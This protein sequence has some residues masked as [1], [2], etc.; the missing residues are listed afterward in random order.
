M[1]CLCLI[2]HIL[3]KNLCLGLWI[4]EERKQEVSI[5]TALL[6]WSAFISCCTSKQDMN[7]QSIIY[8]VDFNTSPHVPANE[9]QHILKCHIFQQFL[10]SC[11]FQLHLFPVLIFFFSCFNSKKC[12]K[13]S[14]R[15][16]TCLWNI[17]VASPWSLFLLIRGADRPWDHQETPALLLKTRSWP[18]DWELWRC[19]HPIVPGPFFSCLD[20]NRRLVTDRCHGDTADIKNTQHMQCKSTSKT[21][22]C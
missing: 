7:Y 17:L 10:I 11:F 3:S 12:T 21:S 1:F 16:A 15:T 18:A 4:T 13:W 5:N 19:W 9:I 8:L 6:C 14:W 22:G 20:S 2:E